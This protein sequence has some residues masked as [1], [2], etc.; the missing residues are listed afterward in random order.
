MGALK[1]LP[2]NGFWLRARGPTRCAQPGHRHCEAKEFGYNEIIVQNRGAHQWND[3]L[4]G[5]I[6]AVVIQGN[7]A[8][9]GTKGA[10]AAQM[11][12]AFL[13]RYGLSASNIPLL[14]YDWWA[15]DGKPFTL[16]DG[17]YS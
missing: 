2:G 9:H 8:L 1:I 11:H 15:E 7:A 6:R 12:A 17:H 5:V 16:W 14:Q 10:L 3:L 4:P 13:Q